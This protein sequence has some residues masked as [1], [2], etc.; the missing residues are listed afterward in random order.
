MLIA[1]DFLKGINFGETEHR[2][3]REFF[4][5]ESREEHHNHFSSAADMMLTPRPH[6]PALAVLVMVV[7]I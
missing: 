7:L 1:V 4:L 2:V 5:D 3:Q 6:P